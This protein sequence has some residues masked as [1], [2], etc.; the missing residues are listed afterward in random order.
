MVEAFGN[1]LEIARDVPDEARA[2][3]LV[4]AAGG[5]ERVPFP[6]LVFTG[7]DGARH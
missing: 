2:A 3:G 4:V 5:K 7:E 1:D 6:T